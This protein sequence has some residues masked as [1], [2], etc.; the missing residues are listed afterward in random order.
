MPSFAVSLPL[1]VEI[2][3]HFHNRGLIISNS[4]G[5]NSENPHK[6][7]GQLGGVIVAGVCLLI[8]CSQ[9]FFS[10]LLF[11]FL[12]IISWQISMAARIISIFRYSFSPQLLLIASQ[13]SS[14]FTDIQIASAPSSATS[15]RE[16]R[17]H[18]SN[19]YRSFFHSLPPLLMFIFAPSI[20]H[21]PRGN[22]KNI[23]VCL[24]D[25]F[26]PKMRWIPD[27]KNS[28]ELVSIFHLFCAPVVVRSRQ[29]SFRANTKCAADGNHFC[30]LPGLLSL[31][32][33]ALA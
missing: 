30:N 27:G 16:M 11:A 15:K 17:K 1:G 24:S 9:L 20:H 8:S 19:V 2:G 29:I 31:C 23:C 4:E 10:L 32:D 26:Q 28:I 18:F 12:I 14:I 3:T 33:C 22:Q 5:Y 21:H 13:N 6:H 7:L 25:E